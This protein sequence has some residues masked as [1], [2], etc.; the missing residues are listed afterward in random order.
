MYMN[1]YLVNLKAYIP[2]YLFYWNQN[3]LREEEWVVRK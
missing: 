3:A 1:I 2:P